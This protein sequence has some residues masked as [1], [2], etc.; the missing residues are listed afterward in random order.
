MTEAPFL[1]A[2]VS[3]PDAPSLSVIVPVFNEQDSVDTF[4]EHTFPPLIATGTDWSVVFINDGSND[5]TLRVLI[6][7]AKRTHRIRVVNLARNFGK[8]AALTAGLDVIDSDV[9]I[10]MDVDL[11]DPPE[12]IPEFVDQWRKGFDVV[13]GV[14]AARRDDTALKRSTAGLFYRVFNKV[15]PTK[16]PENAGDFR[17]MDRRVVDAVKQLPERNRFMKGLFAWV[18]L[19]STGVEFDRAPRAAGKTKF[20]FRGLWN[21]ALDGLLSFSTMPLK[22]WTYV[23]AGLAVGAIGYAGVVIAQTLIFGIAVP[24]YASLMVVLL[25]ASA[26]QLLSLGVIGEYI[27]RLTLEAKQR[28]IFLIEGQYDRRSLLGATDKSEDTTKGIDT[29][30]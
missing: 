3:R 8:E 30:A 21:F 6:E 10:I 12:L 9:C 24:G 11:Q 17:L 28:P 4:L 23:G 26:A 16:I 20:K 7:A 25:L 29:A 22:A 15:S 13:Y 2:G 14:R 18:G 5:Q 19:P 27:A 1:P